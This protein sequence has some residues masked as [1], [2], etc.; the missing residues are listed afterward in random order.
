MGYGLSLIAKAGHISRCH[1]WGKW[2]LWQAVWSGGCAS[3]TPWQPCSPALSWVWEFLNKGSCKICGTAYLKGIRRGEPQQAAW[4]RASGP[5]TDVF[6]SR[7]A[8]SYRHCQPTQS[9]SPNSHT[10]VCILG[11]PWTARVTSASDSPGV[12][13]SALPLEALRTDWDTHR[14]DSELEVT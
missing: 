6:W 14:P 12:L 8:A 11:C 9:G 2:D 5:S 1:T 10:S 13:S 4:G 7:T 3:S